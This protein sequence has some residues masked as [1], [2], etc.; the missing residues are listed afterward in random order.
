[1]TLQN[2]I[3]LILVIV[4]SSYIARK[5]YRSTRHDGTKEGCAKCDVIK[6]NKIKT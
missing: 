3:V 1:M 6:E 2:I 5:I 4:S